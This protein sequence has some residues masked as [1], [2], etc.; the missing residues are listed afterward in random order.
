MSSYLVGGR[1][2]EDT[3]RLDLD[4]ESILQLQ[5]PAQIRNMSFESLIRVKDKIVAIF[6]MNGA[7]VNPN[8]VAV[9]IDPTTQKTSLIPFPATEYRITDA[10]AIDPDGRFWVLN[11][12]WPGDF[13]VSHPAKDILFTKQ[14]NLPS[15]DKD[16]VIERI[17]A[18]KYS[19]TRIGHVEG[20]PIY[21][22]TQGEGSGNNWEGIVRLNDR[23]F[24]IVTDKHPKTILAFVAFE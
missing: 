21:L 14:V 5:L 20:E 15:F 17:V 16:Q 2:S 8:P 1:I 7:N 9:Q 12:Y 3:R 6:E 18:F 4:P 11:Y 13:G 23:G 24:L 19:D 10:T 22:V